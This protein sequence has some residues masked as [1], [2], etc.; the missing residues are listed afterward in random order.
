MQEYIY[1]WSLLAT[2]IH[3]AID[4]LE[5]ESCAESHVITRLHVFEHG[6]RHVAAELAI[7]RA[8]ALRLASDALS[9]E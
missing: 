1:N 4:R 3:A 6:W 5:T 8:D 2:N 7:L 9:V